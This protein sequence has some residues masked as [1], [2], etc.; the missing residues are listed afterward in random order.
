MRISFWRLVTAAAR[1]WH[2]RL[3]CT[4]AWEHYSTIFDHRGRRVGEKWI[5]LRCEKIR[6]FEINSG[7]ID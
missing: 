4:H 3:T 1:H 2:K 6:T 7:L 5:C